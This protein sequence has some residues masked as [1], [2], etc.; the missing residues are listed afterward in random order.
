MDFQNPNPIKW[1]EILIFK[2]QKIIESKF[3]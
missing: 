2:V 1:I 3:D